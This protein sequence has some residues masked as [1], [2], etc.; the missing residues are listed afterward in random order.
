MSTTP[1]RAL[2]TGSSRGIGRAIAV[3]LAEAGFAVTVN[4]RSNRDAADAL[5]ADLT[6]R[7]LSARALGFDVADGDAVRAL[8]E[9]DVQEHG[10][11]WCVVHNAGV[12][13]DGP[14]ASMTPEAWNRVL[15]TN[16]DGFYNVV[17]PLIMPMVRLR[18]GGR[19]LAIGS[20]SGIKG[21]R[22]QANYAASKAG[23]VGAVKSLAPELAKRA[24]TVNCVAPGFIETDMVADVPLE[25]VVE[26]IPLK[27]TGRPEEVAGL[28]GFL[29]SERG[30]YVTGQCWAID[31]GMT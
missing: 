29:A 19:I 13:A 10:A 20:V 22:G 9:A 7:G 23:L 18:D 14:M 26:Q 12:T 24:I 28:V 4:F 8:L 16:L 11:Y 30:G 5:V 17:Q 3:E 2:V 25:A 27:R 31:G 6:G 1:K 21:N 15:R